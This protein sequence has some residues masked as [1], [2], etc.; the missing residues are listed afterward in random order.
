MRTIS[1]NS[2]GGGAEPTLRQPNVGLLVWQTLLASLW[3][4]SENP[5]HHKGMPAPGRWQVDLIYPGTLAEWLQTRHWH[6][7]WT[8]IGLVNTAGPDLAT[9]WEPAS[10]NS[11]ATRV[12]FNDRA[13]Q[14]TSR[15]RPILG[16]LG[17]FADLPL[18]PVRV[19]ASLGA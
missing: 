2:L 11:S 19:K 12:S 14:A 10:C 13:C 3:W 6:W 5:C 8:C 17:T 7:V 18:G 1:P 15:W 4:L 16:C 9:H